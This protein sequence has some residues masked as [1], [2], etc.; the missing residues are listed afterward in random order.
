MV[1]ARSD[2]LLCRWW[3]S[4]LGYRFIAEAALMVGLFVLYKLVRYAVRGQ[5]SEAFAHAR[6]I[7][8]LERALRFFTEPSLQHLV[9]HHPGIVRALNRYYVGMHFPVTIVALIWL[10]VRL[11]EAYLRTRR[12]LVITTGLGL[13]I[14]VLYPL[15]PPRMLP[16]F[17]FVDTGMEFG[18]SAY[19]AGSAFQGIANQFAAM[20]SLHFGWSIII[21]IAIIRN[22]RTSLR[23]LIVAHPVLTTAAIVLTANHYWMDVI[24]AAALLGFVY[25]GIAL[26]PDA[27][28]HRRAGRGHLDDDPDAHGPAIVLDDY[29]VID[30]REQHD[31]SSHASS[32]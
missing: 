11:P 28:L 5:A 6:E 1:E 25:A 31:V 4:R 19:G 29:A 10:Y 18:P 8:H 7:I 32:A 3:R 17:G 22:G 20:P 26:A 2:S 27:R 12:V 16:G 15:A 30:L 23:W 13:V 14:H 24:A 21:A 9:L